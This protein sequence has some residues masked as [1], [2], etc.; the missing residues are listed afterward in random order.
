[1][2][3]KEQKE[4]WIVAWAE[5]DGW[6]DCVTTGSDIFSSKEEA[7]AAVEKNYQEELDNHFIQTDKNYKPLKIDPATVTGYRHV[8]NFPECEN[9]RYQWVIG[10]K[11]L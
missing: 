5:F 10:K 2:A 11:I 6:Q 1:M 8:F 4:Y 7:I 3:N 9:Y